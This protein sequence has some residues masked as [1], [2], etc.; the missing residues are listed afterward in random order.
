MLV[1]WH[2]HCPIHGS[3]TRVSNENK[4]GRYFSNEKVH[5]HIHD[6]GVDGDFH[7]DVRYIGRRTDAEN[8]QKLFDELRKAEFL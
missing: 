1:L 5:N 3:E 8:A 7:P 2:S 6:D 4:E